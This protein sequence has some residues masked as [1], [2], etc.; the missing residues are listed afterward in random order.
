[1][2]AICTTRMR[3]KLE[4]ELGEDPEF[5]R[6]LDEVVARRLDPASA[7][8]EILARELSDDS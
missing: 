5:G 4:A 7:A 3:R 2:V 1:V 8:T 6:L